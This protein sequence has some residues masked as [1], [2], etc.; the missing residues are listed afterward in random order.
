MQGSTGFPSLEDLK[1][2]VRP[3]AAPADGSAAAKQDWLSALVCGFDVDIPIEKLQENTMG[4]PCW[5]ARH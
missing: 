2:A 5:Q 4:A 3:A 1:I